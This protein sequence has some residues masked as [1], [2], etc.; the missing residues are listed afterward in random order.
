MGFHEREIREFTDWINN[1]FSNAWKLQKVRNIINDLSSGVLLLHLTETLKCTTLPLINKNPRNVTQKMENI[2]MSLGALR[3]DGVEMPGI[4]AQD[5]AE[6]DVEVILTLCCYLKRHYTTKKTQNN[7]ATISTT[8][9]T[10]DI[11]EA[12]VIEPEE[13]AQHIPQT[14]AVSPASRRHAPRTQRTKQQEQD[15]GLFLW[16][17]NLDDFVPF[18]KEDIAVLD[19]VSSM[20]GRVVDD[21]LAFKDGMILCDVV[22]CI[23]LRQIPQKVIDRSSPTE[24][25]KLALNTASYELGIETQLTTQDIACGKHRKSFRQYLCLFREIHAKQLESLRAKRR[26][27][28]K[29]WSD[30]LVRD[31]LPNLQ[32][33]ATGQSEEPSTERGPSVNNGCTNTMNGNWNKSLY[34]NDRKREVKHFDERSSSCLSESRIS[35][36]DGVISGRKSGCSFLSSG[37]G[38][39]GEE[40]AQ[41]ERRTK[42]AILKRQLATMERSIGELKSR[43]KNHGRSKSDNMNA[44]SNENCSRRQNYNS[45]IA[46]SCSQ[47]SGLRDSNDNAISASGDFISSQAVADR[48][49]GKK[50]R[51]N[52]DDSASLFKKTSLQDDLSSEVS[53]GCGKSLTSM[54]ARDCTTTNDDDDNDD[55]KVSKRAKDRTARKGQLTSSSRSTS[56]SSL[57]QIAYDVTRLVRQSNRRP[58]GSVED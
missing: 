11:S 21:Y 20:T 51:N 36:L 48:E 6:G 38:L 53:V 56:S 13:N 7:N 12:M 3:D 23:S 32:S 15:L 50:Q 46:E 28:G 26:E 10:S 22:N 18:E 30:N 2:E 17:H 14:L 47:M 37:T 16:T 45:T 29:S 42:H 35:E 24:R 1:V 31:W 4:L 44:N 25:L 52:V 8:M 54:D 19:W 43:M 34:D 9:S 49:Q 57:S 27:L 58:K 41:N 5:V 33:T 40:L 39:T 55:L